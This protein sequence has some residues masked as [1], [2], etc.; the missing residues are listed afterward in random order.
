MLFT[1]K[2]LAQGILSVGLM[3]GLNAGLRAE[4]SAE[5]QKQSVKVEQEE[6][7]PVE[8]K[9]ELVVTE[10]VKEEDLT[11]AAK[12][13]LA[14]GESLLDKVVVDGHSGVAFNDAMLLLG[15]STGAQITL[16]PEMSDPELLKKPV[17]VTAGMPLR[18]ELDNI[19]AQVNGKWESA[20]NGVTIVL[21]KAKSVVEVAEKN[22]SPYKTTLNIRCGGIPL[23]AFAA[24]L[25]QRTGVGVS[26]PQALQS[27]L[28]EVAVEGW[29]M[30]RVLNY[31]CFQY[32]LQMT[33]TKDGVSLVKKTD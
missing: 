11:P 33:K 3:L 19:C 30:E 29:E 31:V 27:Q 14:S 25:T 4:D 32:D 22:E 18:E 6:A 26:V 12:A 15:R 20:D 1:N 24:E 5:E 17:N 23:G 21:S 28:V 2:Q 9:S 8:A 16:T 10:E 7:A 13:A